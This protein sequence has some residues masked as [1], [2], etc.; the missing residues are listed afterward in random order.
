MNNLIISMTTKSM[1]IVVNG[2][3]QGDPFSGIC[4]LIYNADLTKIPILRLGE[5]ILLFVDNAA[6]IVIGKDFLKPMQSYATL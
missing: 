6:I 3:D 4:Y 2:L 1:F 5:W